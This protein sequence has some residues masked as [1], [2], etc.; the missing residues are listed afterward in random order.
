MTRTLGEELTEKILAGTPG[1]LIKSHEH[2]EALREIRAVCHDPERLWPLATFDLDRGMLFEEH[3]GVD[4][5]ISVPKHW[6]E[7][8]DDAGQCKYVESNTPNPMLDCGKAIKGMLGMKINKKTADGDPLPGILVILNSQ[9][10]LSQMAALVQVVANRLEWSKEHNLHIVLLQPTGE[11]PIELRRLFESGHI[12]HNLPDRAQIEEIVNSVAVPPLTGE[13]LE[14]IIDSAAGLTRGGVEDAVAI[15]Q[16]RYGDVRPDVIF[17]IKAEAFA[18]DN[19]AIE[20]SRGG[21]TFEHYGGAP[22]LKQ[23]VRELL[24]RPRSDDPKLRPKGVLLVGPPGVGKSFFAKCAG[25]EVNRATALVTLGALKSKYQ[26]ASFENLLGLIETLEA[27]APLIVFMDE[28]EGQV[29]GGK[30]TGSMDAGTT[31]Q[32]N[33]KLLSWMNDRT[34]DIFLIAAC[35]DTR[36]LMRDMPEFARMGRFD[37]LFFLDYPDRASK[38]EIWKL[39]LISYGLLQPDQ[40]L[41]EIKLPQDDEWTGSEIEACCRLA[42]LRGIS[43]EQVGE[44]MPTIAQQAPERI[45]A[46]REWADGKCFAAE[47]E[48]IYK[49]N[50]HAKK[51]KQMLQEGSPIASANGRR[52]RVI[53]K[54]IDKPNLN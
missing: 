53:N 1:I 49:K 5:W 20:L 41:S 13:P 29:S 23:F 16:V 3:A 7:Q 6:I 54:N 33:S 10:L 14:A 32:I 36:A 28:I 51:L 39:H 48:G 26:G 12:R 45:E 30:D 19:N 22:F 24:I 34:S 2:A 35:N 11:L 40:P 47:Y 8:H 15:S 31:S 27:M 9:R 17:D 50:D 4:G 52:R 38:D 42:R 37:G 43:V 21:L 18:A 25:A 44:N 46:V